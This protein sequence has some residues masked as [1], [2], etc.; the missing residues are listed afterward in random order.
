MFFLNIILC[1]DQRQDLLLLL[2]LQSNIASFKKSIV[3]KMLMTNM[4]MGAKKPH[5]KSIFKV[6][7]QFDQIQKE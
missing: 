3:I 5:R 2:E 6:R 7:L 1:T 4:Q